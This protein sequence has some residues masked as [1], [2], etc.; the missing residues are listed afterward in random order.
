MYVR[1]RKT[2]AIPILMTA[3]LGMILVGIALQAGC[4]TSARPLSDPQ[5]EMIAKG[6]DLFFNET[7]KRK[8]TILRNMPSC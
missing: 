7:F 2:K 4:E 3:A 1:E 5:S 6:R 8:R